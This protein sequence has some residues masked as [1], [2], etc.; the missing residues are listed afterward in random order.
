MSVIQYKDTKNTSEQEE[1]LTHEECAEMAGEEE[2]PV[3]GNVDPVY[4]DQSAEDILAVNETSGFK[5]QLVNNVWTPVAR[6]LW[7]QFK[8]L[9]E[10][11]PSTILFVKIE[12]G[13]SKYRGKP[14]IMECSVMSARWSELLE[15]VTNKSFSHVITIY[16]G[17]VD[18]YE[19][20]HN[21]MLVHLYNAMRQIKS[22]GLLRDYDIRAFSEVYANLKSGWDK[23]HCFIPNLIDTGNWLGMHQQQGQLFGEDRSGENALAKDF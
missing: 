9:H 18:K 6:K 23:E 12:D 2:K 15:Q 4:K 13:K 14:R 17:N 3:F 11:N 22:D 8:E 16:Q 19:Q 5:Y 1:F 10:C 20:S 7:K 21:Q